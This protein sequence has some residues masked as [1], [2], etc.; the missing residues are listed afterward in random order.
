MVYDPNYDP[1]LEERRRQGR[2]EMEGIADTPE[3]VN[4]APWD[5][6]YRLWMKQALGRNGGAPA[7]IPNAAPAGNLPDV[8]YPGG[9]DFPAAGS[10]PPPQ[11]PF[12]IGN[13]E[14]LY[15]KPEQVPNSP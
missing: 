8:G 3:Q 1:V 7:E 5:V 9:A 2:A 11:S 12:H 14:D 6:G 13:L 4:D 15:P 10:P